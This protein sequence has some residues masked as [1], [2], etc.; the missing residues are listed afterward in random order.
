MRCLPRRRRTTAVGRRSRRI[1]PL[2]GWGRRD[3]VVVVLSNKMVAPV[4]VTKGRRWLLG[5][6]RR[7]GG[8]LVVL[9]PSIVD[10][11]RHGGGAPAGPR[12]TLRW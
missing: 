6:P 8:V 3:P 1:W 2:N 10:E 11:L 7:L 12:Q 9:H 5:R 4:Q